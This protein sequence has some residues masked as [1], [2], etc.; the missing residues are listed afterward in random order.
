MIY[1]PGGFTRALES[2][3]WTSCKLGDICTIKTGKLNANASVENGEYPF[4]TCAQEAI[5][6]PSYSF[7]TSAVILAGNGD[8]NVKLYR[9]KFEAY[10]RT[11][12]LSPSN[13]N[14]LYLL[15][16]AVENSMGVLAKGASGSTIKFLTKGMIE[17]IA[18]LIPEDNVLSSFNIISEAIQQKIEVAKRTIADAVEAR[19]R[20]LPK[21]MSG[22]LEV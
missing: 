3:M 6:A 2:S 11:Y 20:L 9:G 17:N 8:F 5:K 13:V 22:E 21:L 19:D 15:Y 12:V 18:L 14:N 7:D 16:H 1:S 10:Q 4:F